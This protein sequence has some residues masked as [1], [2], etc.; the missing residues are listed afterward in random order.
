MRFTELRYV[1]LASLQYPVSGSNGCL[2]DKE[3]AM[4]SSAFPS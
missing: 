2:Q 1:E 3:I 4:G